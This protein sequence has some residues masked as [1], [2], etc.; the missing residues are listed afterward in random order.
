MIN[1]RG[2]VGEN[3]RLVGARPS[4][5]VAQLAV[6]EGGLPDHVGQRLLQEVGA[7]CAGEELQQGGPCVTVVL[8]G[9]NMKGEC[10]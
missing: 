7:R 4:V 10:Y 5:K 6:R 2:S 8:A 3:E 9:V 1:S